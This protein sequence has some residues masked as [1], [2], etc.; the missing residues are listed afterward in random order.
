MFVRYAD[1]LID[2]IDPE[3]IIRRRYFRESCTAVA[4]LPLAAAGSSPGAVGGGRYLK[5]LAQ[6][7]P[8]E[9]WPERAV[10]VD[11]SPCAYDRTCPKNV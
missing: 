6:V 5:D 4:S 8:P 9:H 2:Q 1:P 7:V 10:L 3:G 11:N